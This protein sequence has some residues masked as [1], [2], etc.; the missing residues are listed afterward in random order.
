[1][2]LTSFNTYMENQSAD[3]RKNINMRLMPT[4]WLISLML[5]KK[6]KKRSEEKKNTLEDMLYKPWFIK[7]E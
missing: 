1:M 5:K 3:I 7:W 6:N 2:I 4:C